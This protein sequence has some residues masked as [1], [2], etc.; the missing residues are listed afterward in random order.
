MFSFLIRSFIFNSYLSKN[1]NYWQVDSNTYH[2]IAKS[3]SSGHGY[4]VNGKQN[5]YRLPG[6][7]M[8]LAS[9]Y[10]LFG[11]D[12]KNVLWFQIL[13][14]SLIPVLIFLLSLILFPKS[15]VLAKLSSLYSAIQIGLVLYSGFF[16]SETLFIFLF[17]FFLI[18]YFYKGT[19][20]RIKSGMTNAESEHYLVNTKYGL[21][22]SNIGLGT[23]SINS[24]VGTVIPACP[25]KP[26]AKTGDYDPGS[27]SC[28]SKFQRSS[29]SAFKNLFVAGIF[30]GLAGLVRPV[31]HYLLFLSVILIFLNNL[32]FKNN[33]IS[34]VIPGLIGDPDIKKK[35]KLNIKKSL[36]LTLGFIIVVSPWLVR[37]YV[38]QGQV[39]FHTLPGGHF[40]NFAAARS[41]ML[42][43]GCSYDKT[44][45]ILRKKVSLLA[46]EKKN[47]LGRDLNEIEYCNLQFD[48]AFKYFKKYPFIT[49]KNFLIDIFRTSFSLYSAEILYLENNR[50]S[51][52]YFSNKRTVWDLLKR[53]LI[54][55]TKNIYLKLLVYFEIV[56]FLFILLGVFGSFLV[57]LF[58]Y[59]GFVLESKF[60]SMFAFISFFLVIGLA[61]GYARMRLPIEPL[62][63][64]VSFGFYTNIFKLDI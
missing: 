26:M 58:C 46:Q 5:F 55:P 52:D 4:S 41:A 40:L 25:S 44:K 3:I 63:I 45:E 47:E 16:M 9:F 29:S 34:L 14:G 31:G 42:E 37:N 30:L 59:S 49:I 13:L 23:G 38:A 61:G 22:E 62:L 54:P 32:N 2:K 64:L 60:F 35:L 21:N 7:P 36:F 50:Q 39:F 43:E 28:T 48:L 8:F 24:A 18:F 51:I 17:I 57:Y 53:Y 20:S 1:N 56:L 15:L 33:K 19:R 12:T 10:K 11:V 6:Y 27:P